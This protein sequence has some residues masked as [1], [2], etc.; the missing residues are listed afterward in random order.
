MGYLTG[1]NAAINVAGVELACLRKFE[2]ES[3][4]I[5]VGG[6]CS[7][8]NQG[9]IQVPGNTDWRGVAMAFGAEPPVMPGDAFAFKGGDHT[10]GVWA[11]GN[12]IVDKLRVHWDVEGAEL[13]YYYIWFSGNGVLSIAEGD[14]DADEGT[15]APVSARGMHL[16]IGGTEYPIRKAQLTVECMNAAYNDSSTGGVTARAA[17]NFR[18]SLEADTYIATLAATDLPAKDTLTTCSIETVAGGGDRSGYTVDYLIVDKV[19]PILS[20]EGDNSGRAEGDHALL[21]GRWSSHLADGTA[22]ELSG[23]ADYIWTAGGTM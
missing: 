20:V 11:S 7:A 16:W 2:L 23:P 15:P 17:G 9:E 18:A 3:L 1:E 4:A 10:D 13:L 14:V 8:S 12:V 21:S 6:F 22:G 5:P 19:Q